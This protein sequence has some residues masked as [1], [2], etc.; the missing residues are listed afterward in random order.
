MQQK[1]RLATKTKRGDKKYRRLAGKSKHL[2]KPMY[3]SFFES[4]PIGLYRSTPE[5]QLLDANPA[6]VAMLGYPD[7]ERLKTIRIQD[8]FVDLDDRQKQQAQLDKTGIVQHSEIRLRREDGSILWVKDNLRKTVDQ[9]GNVIYEGS[10]ED[11]TARKL[12]EEA[13]Q[14][15]EARLRAVLDSSLLS[16]ILIDP[17]YRISTFNRKANEICQRYLGQRI[18]EGTSFLSY[19]D[20]GDRKD[21]IE[22]F[23]QALNGKPT[24][25]EYPL[26][27]ADGSEEWFEFHWDPTIT[28]EDQ[29]V[30]VS[31]SGIV[32]TPGKIAEQRIQQLYEAEREQRELAE[33]LQETALTLVFTLE[34]DTILDRILDQVAKVVPYDIGRVLL[35]ENRQARVVRVKGWGPFNRSDVDQLLDTIFN[36][37][38]T[39]NLRWVLD[40]GQPLIIPDT[41]A[42]PGWIKMKGSEFIR[43]WIGIPIQV[44]GE[45]LAV[46]SLSKLEPNFYKPEHAKILAAFAGQAALALHHAR[47]FET[48][49]RRAR[50]AEMLRQA[51]A[52]VINELNLDQALDQIL[53]NL[54]RVIQ[55]DSAAIFLLDNNQLTI[56]AARGFSNENKVI[57]LTFPADNLLFRESLTTGRAIILADAANDARFEP[58]ISGYLVHGWMGVPLHLRG[59]A[60]GFLTIDCHET[61]AYSESEASL[62]QAFANEASIAIENARLFKELQNLATTDPLTEVWNRRHFI[63]LAKIEFRARPSIPPAI[64]DHPV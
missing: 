9:L 28:E 62:A 44:H 25:I 27:D 1:Y 14:R 19:L 54:K 24:T 21:F 61:D 49:Q 7:A 30:G 18:Q 17:D 41:T 50:E 57:G 16:F 58:W 8:L 63:Q 5:G 23:S 34:T 51:T 53:D 32:I 22:H 2:S 33:A 38:Q 26:S 47:L 12:S 13:L 48:I 45:L 42:Y 6:M 64:I 3:P 37:D 29:V 35:F 39:P 15:S 56:V 60:I 11:I 10:L 31:F 4:I 52:A 55:Y 36:L 43:S 46:F 59:R 20:E 40:N